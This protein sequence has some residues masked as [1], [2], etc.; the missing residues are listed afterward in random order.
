MFKKIEFKHR[1][2]RLD[3]IFDDLKHD[4]FVNE[5]KLKPKT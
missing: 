2:I 4:S 1:T 3:H 5:Q